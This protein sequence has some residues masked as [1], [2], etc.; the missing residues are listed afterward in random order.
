MTAQRSSLEMIQRFLA[1]KRIAMVGVSR[2]PRHFSVVL[3]DELCRRGYDVVP[4]NPNTP[5]IHGHPCAA[6]VLD[7]QPPVTAALLMT[8]PEVTERVM[9]DCYA[10]GVKQV[11]M[12]RAAGKGAV[13]PK[14]VEFCRQRAIEVI[15]GECPFMFLPKAGGVHR[16]HGFLRKIVGS[17]PRHCEVP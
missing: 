13:S 11:W 6:R 12:Y 15:A 9:E 8:S 17:Y 7:I 1:Q 10:A 16:F 3:F 14:A 4:V 5:R 2:E